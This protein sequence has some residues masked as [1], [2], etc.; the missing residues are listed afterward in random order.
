[1]TCRS[2][3]TTTGLKSTPRAN[4]S[5]RT[6]FSHFAIRARGAERLAAFY[7]EVFE[8]EARNEGGGF[9]LTDGRV[10]LSILP[11]R[12][13]D[14]DG[15]GIEQPALDHIGFRVADLEAFK[16]H[17]QNVTRLNPHIAPRP[18]DFNDEGKARLALLKKCPH[19]AYHLADPDGTLI[20]VAQY[21]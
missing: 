7:A 16:A 6:A 14:F 13:S 17:V 9:H 8:L 5:R 11:W 3:A 10:T 12:I 21:H 20:D 1:M 4:G 19:G 18:I 15:S 2:R